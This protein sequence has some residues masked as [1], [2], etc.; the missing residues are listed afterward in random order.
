MTSIVRLYEHGGPDVLRW[1]DVELPA[2]GPH[3]VRL[4][5]T[6]IGVNFIDVYH[7]TGLYPLRLP[8]SL[9]SEAAGIV[10][11]VGADVEEFVPGDRAAYASAA[12]REAYSEARNIDAADLVPLPEGIVDAQAA[13]MMLKGMTAWYLLT[14]SYA[15][16]PGDTILFHAAAGG[17]GLIAVQWA[18]HLGA[19][20][21]GTVGSEEK[22]ELAMRHGCDHTIVVGSGESV[23][24]AVHRITHGAKLPVVYDSVGR[25]TF[26]AS[27]DCLRPHGLLVSFGN[28]SGPV[29]PFSLLELSKRGSL[30][31]TRPVLF[32]FI[33]EKGALVEAAGAL[34]DLV[35]R[36]A[37]EI[38]VNQRFALK[39]AAQ[40]HRALEARKT[41]G[42]IVLLP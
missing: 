11:E 6:A 23:P 27:L 31:V 7:R 13:G 1:E 4:R 41:T 18:K 15:V 5:H 40:A 25:D 3:E 42:S 19:T 21:I 36:G 34:F 38:R 20:V 9:G 33:N 30:H 2:P 32:D 16:Q 29:E 26:F 28:A 22:A 10:E 39:D 12:A 24:D 17:V 37:V 14:R 35:L 8:H